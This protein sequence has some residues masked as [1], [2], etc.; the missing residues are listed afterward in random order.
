M[1]MH[2][3]LR[4]GSDVDFAEICMQIDRSAYY[5]LGNDYNVFPQIKFVLPPT[6]LAGT[7]V[8]GFRTTWVGAYNRRYD[9]SGQAASRSAESLGTGAHVMSYSS[10]PS[11]SQ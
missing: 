5:Y 11:A 1:I 8:A 2:I 10:G 4:P 6:F 7:S 9:A 3:F